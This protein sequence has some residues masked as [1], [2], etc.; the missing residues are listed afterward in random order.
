M[1]VRILGDNQYVLDSKYLD[2]LN[3]LDSCMVDHLSNEEVGE[4]NSCLREMI[5]I[6][7]EK[8]TPLDPAEIRPSD[9][10]VPSPDITPDEAR[11]L[12]T[13]EGMIPG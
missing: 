11:K 1:I 9:L 4:F 13:K 5:H 7:R 6:I 12:F 8:G 3:E 2:K 10:I